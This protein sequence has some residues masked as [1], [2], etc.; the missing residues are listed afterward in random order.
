MPAL[1]FQ[2]RFAPDV[3]LGKKR[4]SIRACRRDGR[5]P[6]QG[7]TLY[8]YTGQRTRGCRKLRED[9][10]KSS[11]IITIDE[12]YIY[13]AGHILTDKECLQ[14]AIA[15]GFPDVQE[16]R[17]FFDRPPEGLPFTGYLIKW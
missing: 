15:D 13:V 2:K 7:Q 10:C 4:Q 11:E 9:I 14:M 12:N 1:N 6:R 16:F 3:E 8:L 5:N 17:A